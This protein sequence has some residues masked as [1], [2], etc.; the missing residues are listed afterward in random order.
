[1][2]ARQDA[3]RN[4]DIQRFHLG[5]RKGREGETMALPAIPRQPNDC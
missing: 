3:R 1:L 2:S 5:F 4:E